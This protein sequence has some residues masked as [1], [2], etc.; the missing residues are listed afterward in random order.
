MDS[1][2]IPRSKGLLRLPDV[3]NPPNCQTSR[4]FL[5]KDSPSELPWLHHLLGQTSSGAHPPVAAPT[6]LPQHLRRP[7]ELRTESAGT[8]IVG[9]S[10]STSSP[11]RGEHLKKIKL[12]HRVFDPSI[13]LWGC[14]FMV[15]LKF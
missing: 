7:G 6:P 4:G 8:A 15:L 2:R 9:G 3:P 1:E 11:N 14:F 13:H 5:R 10:V 12:H